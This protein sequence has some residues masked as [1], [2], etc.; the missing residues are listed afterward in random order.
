MRISGLVAAGAAAL[1]LTGVAVAQ[2]TINDYVRELVEMSPDDGETLIDDI[3]LTEL[4]VYDSDEF[5]FDIDPEKTYY[6]YGACDDDCSD[7]DLEAHDEDEVWVD[8]DDESDDVPMLIIMPGESGEE[9]HVVVSLE[10]CDVD[11]CVVGVGVY[12]VDE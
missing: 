4:D 2:Q 10:D 7:I 3:R 12:E 5:I 1:A 11:T 6:V 8:S 9:L